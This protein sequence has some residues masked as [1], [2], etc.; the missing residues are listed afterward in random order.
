M[1]WKNDPK[2]S[3]LRELVEINSGTGNPSG[4]N[5]VQDRVALEL[6]KLG[7]EIEFKTHPDSPKSDE[8]CGKF[9]IATREGNSSAQFINFVTH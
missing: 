8:N 3:L 2:V 9:L 1:N 7:F 5:Q 6:K 4:V